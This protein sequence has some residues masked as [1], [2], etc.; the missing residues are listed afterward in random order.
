[1]QIKIEIDVKPEELRRFL[2]LPDVAGLQ[3]DVIQFLRDKLGAASENFDPAGFLREN[4][5]T[6]RNSGTWKR[7]VAAAR[8]KAPPAPQQAQPAAAKKPARKKSRAAARSKT[9]SRPKRARAAR[10]TAAFPQADVAAGTDAASVAASDK[11]AD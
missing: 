1:M 11:P 10:K 7:I 9:A 8:T 6:L 5:L 4:L 2:G 3:E